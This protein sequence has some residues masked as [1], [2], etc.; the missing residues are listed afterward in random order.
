MFWVV[1]ERMIS[2]IEVAKMNFFHMVAGLREGKGLGTQLS[3]GILVGLLF[4]HVKRS[5]LGW[6][7][8]LIRTPPGCLPLEVFWA[9][10]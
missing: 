5:Q 3:R 6:F 2:Q 7:L 1:A 4:G 9:L 8:Y 10:R